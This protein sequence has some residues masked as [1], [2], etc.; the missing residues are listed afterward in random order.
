MKAHTIARHYFFLVILIL[1]M[2]LGAITGYTNPDFAKS[3][4][5][6]GT[7]FI[8]I[9]FCIVVPMVFASISGAVAGTGSLKRSGKIIW[10][11]IITFIITGTIY[12]GISAGFDS[13]DEYSS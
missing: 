9:M 13:M 11:T 7:I 1:A 3:I 8:R 12:N 5:F 10:T 2:I 4:S 6:L